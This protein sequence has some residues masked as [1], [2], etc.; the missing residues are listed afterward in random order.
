MVKYG[1]NNGELYD[2]TGDDIGN[3]A[4]EVCNN[5]HDI[6]TLYDDRSIDYDN[7]IDGN[8]NSDNVNGLLWWVM[9]ITVGHIM[10][11]MPPVAFKKQQASIK[12]LYGLKNG[13]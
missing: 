5:G 7:Y 6:G 8:S 12:G 4:D 2:D 9:I 13:K 1:D 10:I 3:G 11:I